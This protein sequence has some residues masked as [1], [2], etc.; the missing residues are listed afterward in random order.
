MYYVN[1]AGSQATCM[2]IIQSNYNK[3]YILS[4]IINVLVAKDMSSGIHKVD[5]IMALFLD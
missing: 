1:C 3:L 5:L 4:L 2:L